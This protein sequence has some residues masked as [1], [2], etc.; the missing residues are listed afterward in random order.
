MVD[1]CACAFNSHFWDLT[2]ISYTLFY[3]KNYFGSRDGP[4]VR[5]LAYL[6]LMWPGLDSWTMHHKW[7]EFVGSLLCCKRFFSGYPGFPL[8][9]KNSIGLD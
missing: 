7:V 2:Y 5:V 4:V 8:S 9:K 6:P 3:I 1:S